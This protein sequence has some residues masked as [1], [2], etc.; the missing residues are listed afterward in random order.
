MNHEEYQYLNLIKEILENG[1]VRQDRTKTGTKSIFAPDQLKFNLSDSFPLLTTKKVFLRPIFEELMWFIRGQTNAKILSD[2]NVHIWDANGSR[3]AL[4]S[5]GLS[6]REEGDLGPVYGFQWRHFG[7]D[8][9]DFN[10]DYTNQGV[11]QLKLII[12][13]LLFNP[14][15][16]RIILTAWNPKAIPDMALP[17]CHMFC[18]F[19]VSFPSEGKPRLSCQLYQRSCDVGLGVPFNIASYALLTY[20]IAHV[21]GLEPYQFIHCMGDTH[22]Y[23]D[24]L[25]ALESQLSRT[26]NAFPTIK[27]N[28]PKPEFNLENISNEGKDVLVEKL[29][30][31]LESFEF[32]D[33]ELVNYKPHGKIVMKMSV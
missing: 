24:H 25:D 10:T 27:I 9:T 29:L 21:C 13:S 19:Y 14:T 26:P 20:L 32:E 3:E 17:P 28:K 6:H 5:V 15:D 8:Y 23:M 11:D 33:V 2:K 30:K 31:E 4:D 22:I 16:R 7:A 1:E 18:Q 12:K